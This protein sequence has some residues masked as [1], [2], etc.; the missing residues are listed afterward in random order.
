MTFRILLSLLLLPSLLAPPSSATTTSPKAQAVLPASGVWLRLPVIPW[1]NWK[2]GHR[3]LDIQAP[4]DSEVFVPA[5]GIV[6]WV[7]RIGKTVGITI[8]AG[9]S[10]KHTLTGV[11]SELVIGQKVKLGQFA[12]WAITNQHCE[13]LDCIHWSVRQKGRYIDPRW[14][15]KPIVYRLPK[16]ADALVD[17]R[18]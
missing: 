4:A 8:D 13:N 15:L 1:P 3:G 14:L 12:G 11:E 5:T 17:K 9:S 7:G 2:P 6:I 10:I 16:R 18:F